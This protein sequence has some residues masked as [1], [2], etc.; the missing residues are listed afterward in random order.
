VRKLNV[1]VDRVEEE[2]V[3]REALRT[4]A[5]DASDLGYISQRNGDEGNP[6]GMLGAWHPLWAAAASKSIAMSRGVLRKFP[7]QRLMME[8]GLCLVQNRG[9]LGVLGV[10]YRSERQKDGC[11]TNTRQEGT[12]DGGKVQCCD[13]LLLLQAAT[14]RRVPF[15]PWV[16]NS[17]SSETAPGFPI[18]TRG[19][20]HTTG[21]RLK[22]LADS[23]L[24]ICESAANEGGLVFT[25]SRRR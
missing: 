13:A 19:V 12:N 23:L 6:K 17:T 3:W 4:T 16:R 20:G 9:G 22:R 25:C 18:F 14:C 8:Y 15:T 21:R 2:E 11:W 24:L 1:A 10:R 7:F 5:H